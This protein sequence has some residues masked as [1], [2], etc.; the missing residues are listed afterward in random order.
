MVY[1][2]VRLPK[3]L[4]FYRGSGVETIEDGRFSVCWGIE[5]GQGVP[6]PGKGPFLLFHAFTEAG[7]PGGSYSLE[8]TW[9]IIRSMTLLF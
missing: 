2:K 6:P 8:A 5:L 9:T 7:S 1:D 4:P 3:T